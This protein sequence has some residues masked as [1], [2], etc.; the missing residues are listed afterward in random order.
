MSEEMITIS[1]KIPVGMTTLLD[2]M[3]AN[4]DLDRS[5]FV[6]KLIRQEFARRTGMD[7]VK[8]EELP[9]PAGGQ[10]VPVVYISGEEK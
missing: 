9:R 8:I 3:V 6:R 7:V 4:D 10:S 2:Q 5:K 1:L